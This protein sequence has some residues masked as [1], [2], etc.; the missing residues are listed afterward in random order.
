MYKNNE[1]MTKEQHEKFDK[2]IAMGWKD[3][4]SVYMKACEEENLT[5]VYKAKLVLGLFEGAGMNEDDF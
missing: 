5:E 3:V 2:L 4:A 1:H